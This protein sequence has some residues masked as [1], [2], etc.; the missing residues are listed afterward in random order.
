MMFKD[1]WIGVPTSTVNRAIS[2]SGGNLKD[3]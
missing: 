3:S 2:E 1:D